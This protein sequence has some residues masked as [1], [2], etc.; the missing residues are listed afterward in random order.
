MKIEVSSGKITS[1]S[2]SILMVL[3]TLG[4]YS[5]PIFAAPLHQASGVLTITVTDFFKEHRAETRYIMKDKTQGSYELHFTSEP[6][7]L[8]T[9][10]TLKVQ[11]KVNGSFLE[12]TELLAVK[13]SGR[14]SPQASAPTSGMSLPVVT[15]ASGVQNVL[16]YNLQSAAN[17]AMFTNTQLSTGTF[18]TTGLSVNTLYQ[19]SSFGALSL[20]G[21]VEGPFTI[22]PPTTCDITSIQ[23]Q[24]DQA[25]TAAGID[26]AAYPHHVYM[27][28]DELGPLCA[29][30]GTSYLGSGSSWVNTGI[31]FHSM[32]YVIHA[33][34]H[35][36][37]H[38]LN[39]Q[40]SQGVQSDG[41]LSEYGDDSCT[42]GDGTYTIAGVNWGNPDAIVGFNFIHLI[43]MGWIPLTNVQQVTQ[44]GLYQVAYAEQQT[45]A[46][47]GLQIV[48]PGTASNL[49]VSYRQPTGED[50]NIPAVFEQG[51][52]IHYWDG[53]NNKSQL[54]T[55]FPFGGALVDGQ[56]YSPSSGNLNITQI[57]HTSTY[58]ALEI[59]IINPSAP[60]TP[61]LV[62]SAS[63]ALAVAPGSLASIYGINIPNVPVTG[64]STLPFPPTL[65]GVQV[66]VN[67]VV[68]PLLYVSPVQINF[69]IPQSTQ[70]GSA[71]VKIY[72]N[73]ALVAE[74]TQ[75]P[76]AQ[77][78]V[79]IYTVANPTASQP[80][81]LNAYVTYYNN[82][83]ASGLFHTVG[84][85]L[86]TISLDP[87]LG[88]AYLSI[89]ATGVNGVGSVDS[90]I[91]DNYTL[92][93]QTVSTQ[94]SGPQGYDPGLDQIN[95]AL[96]SNL[97]G[98]VTITIP[99]YEQTVLMQVG[100]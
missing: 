97:S 93:Q 31:Y 84:A 75:A 8:R 77:Q 53:S 99:G 68:S 58:V 24:A 54:A 46:I 47:Q 42:M 63:N 41:T 29:W 85:T 61:T 86:N 13:E 66:T 40:H 74:Q 38:Q 39:M 26:I 59:D 23:T 67:N 43:Q 96:P 95:V 4:G 19:Q 16:I 62:N 50:A 12:S 64:F 71:D 5:S 79:G 92:A 30:G 60:L 94:Y 80:A 69:Q 20:I 98:L 51:V 32:Y 49:Y 72:F 57:S 82:G 6:N 34:E 87:S 18:S 35:E 9:G 21:N 7:N 90:V 27:M 3:A 83:K 89:Y 81:F 70:P 56:T 1:P 28:P 44:S 33:I 78:S 91:F 11:G 65:G 37:G 10:M 36:F 22:I 55:L 15:P 14:L 17:P 100:E 2:L 45:S 76:V 88:T 48:P 52:S 73:E 25:G